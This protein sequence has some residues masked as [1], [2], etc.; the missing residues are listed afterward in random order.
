MSQAMVGFRKAEKRKVFLKIALTGPSG[1]GKTLSALMKATGIGSKIAV[2]D[3]ENDSASLYADRFDFDTLSIKPPYTVQKHIDAIKRAVDDGYDVLII[4]SISHVWASDGGLLTKK[5]EL[6]A[7]G[8]GGDRKHKSHF[9]NWGAITKEH[10]QF[11]AWLLQAQIHMICTMRSKQEYAQMADGSVKK[12]GMA[13]IQ[14]DGM[15]YEFTTVLDLAMNHSASASKD[16]TGIFDGQFVVPTKET[17][18]AFVKWLSSGKGELKKPAEVRQLHEEL[19]KKGKAM[20]AEAET[21]GYGVR[22][23]KALVEFNLPDVKSWDD[24]TSGQMDLLL[25]IMRAK[26]KAKLGSEQDMQEAIDETIKSHGAID[27]E[28]IAEGGGDFTGMGVP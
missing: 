19:K 11:K 28:F 17:G 23:V 1:A 18:E 8:S 20:F 26:P 7:R 9:A 12:L 4:D 24:L 5:E 6:D 16:R 14:R 3:T 15:E 21:L 25:Q 27:N 2:I 10:E 22:D 13:P